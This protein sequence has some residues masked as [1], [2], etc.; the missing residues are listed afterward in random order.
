MFWELHW[1]FGLTV[2]LNLNDAFYVSPLKIYQPKLD[3]FVKRNQII[4]NVDERLQARQ[5]EN[6]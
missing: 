4:Q 3:L 5:S 6:L 2:F 1:E